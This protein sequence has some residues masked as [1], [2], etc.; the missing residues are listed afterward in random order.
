MVGV[1]PVLIKNANFIV[2]LLRSK[3]AKRRVKDYIVAIHR[4]ILNIMLKGRLN[5]MDV[6]A[7]EERIARQRVESGEWSEE[8]GRKYVL[9]A[10][11]SLN[12][13]KSKV[14]YE[15]KDRMDEN[16]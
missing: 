2:I 14:E 11:K 7:M 16:E 9:D 3:A 6:I 5:K 13:H 10:E 8:E 1:S 12:F 15:K 4:K